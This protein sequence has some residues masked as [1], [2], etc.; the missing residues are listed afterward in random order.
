MRNL[1]TAVPAGSMELV[2]EIQRHVARGP[3]IFLKMV[4]MLRDETVEYLVIYFRGIHR[5]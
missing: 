4:D 1:P 3:K 2:Q 5:W